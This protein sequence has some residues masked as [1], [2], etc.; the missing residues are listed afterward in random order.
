MVQKRLVRR[1]SQASLHFDL[2]IKVFYIDPELLIGINE[3]IY[4]SASVKHCRMV[5]IATMESDGG[6]GCFGVLFGKEHGKLPCL[7]D[8]S[9]SG[10]G[11][12]QIQGNVEIVTH[13][14][15]DVINGYLPGCALNELID[16][17]FCKFQG[18]G[19]FIE[20]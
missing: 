14:F 13:N 18:N 15:L 3:I 12:D 20:G 9:L 4:C 5:F 17:L 19:L 10:F 11:I 1:N 6:Q 8:L 16:H 2:L 7:D